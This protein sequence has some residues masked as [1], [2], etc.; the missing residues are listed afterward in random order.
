MTAATR[1]GTAHDIAVVGM[2]CRFPGA[3]DRHQ[4]WANLRDGVESVTFFTEEE[5]ASAGVPRRLLDDPAYV[6]A[7]GVLAGADEFDAAFFDIT[8]KEAGFMDPQQR[9]LLECAW[10]ALEDSGYDPQGVP[11]VAGVFAGGFRNDHLALVACS[12][13]PAAVFLRNIG[14]ECDYL[15]SRIAY[16]L[17]LRGPT[18]TVQ[19]AC[20]TSLVAVHLACQ[21]LRT[22]ACDVALAG[23]VTV[24]AGQHPGY[25]FNE[26]GILS[27]DGQCR[28]FD[29]RGEGTVIGDG[30]GLV[31]LKRLDDARADGDS[32][33]AVIRGSATGN[34]GADRVGY[35]APGVDGQARLIQAA[36]EDAG[37]DARSVTYV[38]THGSGTPLGD[39]IELTALTR[40]FEACG[41]RPGSCPYRCAIGSVKTNVGH[42]HAAAGIVGLIKTVLA[43]EHGQLPPSLHFAEPNPRIDFD[44]SPFRVNTELADWARNGSPRRAGVSSFG[45]GGTGAHV[46]LEEAPPR[47]PE[48]RLPSPRT[49]HVLTLSARTEPALEAA[50]D[51]L[52]GHLEAMPEL[53]LA[54]A[55]YTLQVGRH[56]FAYRRTLVARDGQEA[57][58]ALR[59][60]APRTVSSGQPRSN[61]PVAFLFP[62]VGD[63]YV[64][65]GRRLYRSEP[66]FREALDECTNLLRARTGLDLLPLLYP[67]AD[68]PVA[69]GPGPDLRRMLRGGSRSALDLT[70]HA[71]P[72]V[73]AVE[74]ALAR[75]WMAWGV[76][77]D[78]LLGY[79]IGE[80]VAA[81]LAGVL[82][83]DDALFLVAERARLITALPAGAML[84]VS[85]PE[86]R[87]RDELDPDLSLAALNG[88]ELCVVAGPEESITC[89]ERRLADAGTATRRVPTSHAFHSAMMR[90]AAPALTDLV[91]GFALREPQIPYLSNVTGTWVTPSEATDPAYWGRHLCEA[92][93]FA[94]GVARLWAEPDRVALE[95]GPGQALGS[96]ALQARPQRE[97]DRALVLAS[98]P[99]AYDRQSDERFLLDN[100]GKLWLAGVTVQWD[101]MHAG[102]CRSRVPLPTYPFERRPFGASTPSPRPVEPPAPARR[103]LADWFSVPVWDALPPLTAPVEPAGP[104]LRWLLFVDDVGVGDRLAGR[105]AEAGHLVTTVAAGERP[106]D[107]GAGR[108][109]LDPGCPDDY[110]ALLEGLRDS[111]GLP[112]RIVHLWTVTGGDRGCEEIQRRGFTSLLLLAQALG[113]VNVSQPVDISVV[114]SDLHAVHPGAASHPEKAIVLGPCIVLPLEDPNVRCRSIDIALP[115]AGT[116]AE[117][118]AIDLLLA[119]VCSPVEEAVLAHRGPSRW[120]R[121]FVP[122]RLG[123]PAASPLRDRGVYLITGGFGGMA[124]V[125]G[126]HLARTARARLVLT[127]RTPL[128]P[129]AEWGCWTAD[130]DEAD[131]TSRRIRYVEELEAAGSEVLVRCA[132]AT[133][134]AAMQAVVDEACCRFGRIHGA[135]HAAGVAGRGLIQLKDPDA[136][137]RVLAPKLHGGLVLEAVCRPLDLDFLVFCSSSLAVTGA[138][139]QVD[140]CAANAFLDALAQRVTA[141]GGP[142]SASINWDAWRDVGMAFDNL[143]PA[144]G[145]TKLPREVDHPLLDACLYEGPGGATY[146]VTFDARTTWLVDEHRMLGH[147]VVA[148][149]GHLEM[150]R[151]AFADRQGAGPVVLEDVTFYTPIVLRDD[152]AKEVR[153]LLDG[154]GDAEDVDH[155]YRFSVISGQPGGRWQVHSNGTV[156]RLRAPAPRQHDVDTQLTRLRDIGHP[157]RE[158]PM[159]LAGRSRCLEK[160]YVGDREFVA[161]IGLPSQFAADL[162]RL[163]L[164]PSMMD[165]AAAFVGVFVADEFRIPIRYGRIEVMAP[166]PARVYSHQRYREPDG[167][168]RETVTSDFAILDEHGRELVR[169]EE[170]VLK[171]AGDLA[172]R[173]ATVRDGT[174]DEIVDYEYTD[175][176]AGGA[177]SAPSAAPGVRF[178]QEHLEHGIRPDEG[179]E[180]FERVL[181][182]TASAQ[183]IVT[184]LGLGTQPEGA[185]PRS[186]A[187]SPPG[188][189]VSPGPAPPSTTSTRHPRPNLGTP[190][191]APRDEVERDL[192]ALWQELLGLDGIGVHDHFFELGGHSLLGLQLAARLRKVFSVDVPLGVLFEALTVAE[193]ATVITAE[194]ARHEAGVLVT[195]P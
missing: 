70:Q 184:P 152:E 25:L 107:V 94:D 16:K 44:G 153:V 176:A 154:D 194:T 120:R 77:P 22:G 99:P 65:M 190:F 174:S 43:L 114:S 93:R 7:Q 98:L 48:T 140:Y 170:F 87:V 42:L 160:V 100:L 33:R 130:H 96:F 125:L 58:A 104:S 3:A 28:A 15:A 102:D 17:D 11:G 81:C 177:A 75:L 159:G 136:A 166:L 13:D 129:R 84:A 134:L 29:A 18:L 56:Q 40:A 20:S 45:I 52:A 112:Q 175:P 172:T 24:R 23:G 74:Y 146:A 149:T 167:D 60:R 83:L 110:V 89:L 133:D 37:V 151:A 88:P 51:R 32:I 10:E 165:L 90:P 4:F 109:T 132:D 148:G 182:A 73:F 181:A 53:D 41:W 31:V 122:L 168:G 150:V 187:Q 92:V 95:V 156:A 127:S 14:N 179:V 67:E 71:Q 55:A 188:P 161:R 35:T 103:D 78:A 147:A 121:A 106:R 79:S 80:Y 119:E 54:D 63:H 157:A 66:V 137:A 145:R 38:E 57:A 117:Q 34:D 8:P 185:R 46:V 27:S 173:L 5:L 36:L 30:V 163:E 155:R 143:S 180:A 82:T 61:P 115:S 105:L 124:M 91:R 116:W 126:R 47:A 123:S 138:V 162:E 144:T 59:V 191:V 141:T 108:Y 131:S 49:W 6:R 26:G 118:K 193:L 19:T 101:S 113:R 111:D 39:R 50:T 68:E 64:G 2:S 86:H 189:A 192:A 128:P 1:A 178:L 9:L 183:V 186:P 62:G 85:L 171:R 12:D 139:G 142:F 21:T 97:D 195:A 169:V 135:I 158:G 164:H 72:A 69:A 76:E